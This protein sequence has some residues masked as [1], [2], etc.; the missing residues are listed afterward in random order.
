MVR[1]DEV[2]ESDRLGSSPAG[3]AAYFG[4][5]RVD[6][7]V[8]DARRNFA[9]V[10]GIAFLLLS[11]GLW[12]IMWMVMVLRLIRWSGLLVLFRRDVVWCM[13]CVIVLF[14][15]ACGYVGGRVDRSW[16]SACHR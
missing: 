7:A 10:C 4:R 12:L 13:L 5:R 14:A 6:F 15:W 1:D 3:G 2:R 16:F 9:G 11:L 8:V